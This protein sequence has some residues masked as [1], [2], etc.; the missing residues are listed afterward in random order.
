MASGMQVLVTGAGG[1]SGS[2]IAVRLAERGH[3]VTACVGSGPGRLDPEAIRSGRIATI[4]G[5]LAS[6]LELPSRIDAVV[7]AAAR[8]PAPG[9]TDNTILR[10]NIDATR[11]LVEHAVRASVQTFVYLSSL[12]VYGR[13]DASTVDPDTPIQEPDVYGRSKREAERMLEGAPFRVLAIRLPGV[14]G[15]GSVRNWLTGVLAAAKKDGE[16][17]IFNPDSC[18][19][20][21]VHVQDLANFAES[22]LERDWQGFDAVTI[23]ASGSMSVREVVQL[24]VD[25]VQSRSRI[26]IETAPRASFLISSTRA[27]EGYGYAPMEIG[28]MLRQFVAE[29]VD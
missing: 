1:F 27:I 22:L 3:R 12:S 11:R 5:D 2:T 15:R 7:H 9:V 18:F 29:N 20:N 21:A 25:A 8:S 26:R 16:I 4:Q 28:A 19:N 10:D 24:I 6:G 23:G 13:I 17:A 14:I